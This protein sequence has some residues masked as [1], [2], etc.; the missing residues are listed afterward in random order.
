MVRLK[1][2]RNKLKITQREIAESIEI[3]QRQWNRYENGKNEIPIRYIIK[4]CEK[5][6]IDANW[7]LGINKDPT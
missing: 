5:Y 2:L 6:K 7:I 3:D 4:L 1:E